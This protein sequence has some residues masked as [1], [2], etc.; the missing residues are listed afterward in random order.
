[1]S[2]TPPT[3]YT[4]E[5]IQEE[6]VFWRDHYEWLLESGYQ[7][8]PRYKPG[9]V[10]TWK[11]NPDLDYS[12]CEDSVVNLRRIVCDAIRIK[13]NSQVILKQVNR[14]S[15]TKEIELHTFLSETSDPRNPAIPII[16]V[17]EPPDAPEISLLVTPQNRNWNS[18]R[19]G[20]VGEVVDFLGQIIEGFRFLHENLIAHR[21]I[22]SQNILME[23]SA[24]S[25]EHFHFFR[26]YA[27]VDWKKTLTF[28]TRTEGHPRYYII[29]FGLSRRYD[30]TQDPPYEITPMYGT[31]TTVPEFRNLD[32]PH[33]PF[34]ID[35]YCLGNM[36]KTKV[37]GREPATLGFDWIMPLLDDMTRENPEERPDM[38][39]VAKRFA[40]LTLNLKEWKLR[41]K[42]RLA[43][44][45][46]AWYDQTTTIVPH[47][48]RKLRFTVT[49]TPPI[50]TYKPEAAAKP[51]D[52]PKAAG[53]PSTSKLVEGPVSETTS[54]P[55][56]TAKAEEPKANVASEVET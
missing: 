39:A 31:D 19:F 35:V 44:D 10:P 21:D 32:E 56:E 54:E 9:W 14:E 11:T 45:D 13:D 27:S 28:T 12:E 41:S 42:F 25:K 47:W 20:T 18:P 36:I 6:E 37:L 51:V 49:R 5:K 22:K 15:N 52:R 8:R 2:E 50:P 43:W 24:L 30:G 53:E 33:N 1:M 38:D 46:M 34:P 23:A 40:E 29:D 26:A 17:L 55:A 7:L 48:W 4:F 16:E 3:E